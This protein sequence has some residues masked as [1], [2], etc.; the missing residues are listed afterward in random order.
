MRGHQL[1]LSFLFL[2]PEW[3]PLRTWPHPQFPTPEQ[4]NTQAM[5]YTVVV[6]GGVLE[7]NR[8]ADTI[9]TGK[10]G[11][12]TEI[13]SEILSRCVCGGLIGMDLSLI[14]PP[15]VLAGINDSEPGGL[16]EVVRCQRDSGSQT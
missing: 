8:V 14:G 13:H 12:D 16:P 3:F 7:F 10:G 1:D 11:T 15:S 9:E 2:S 5:S 6:L 4:T